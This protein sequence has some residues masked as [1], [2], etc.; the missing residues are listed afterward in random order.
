MSDFKPLCDYGKKVKIALMEQNKKQEWLIAE[1][2]SR[3]PDI[4]V[5][6]SNIHKI[7]TG[8]IASGK[9]VNAINEILAI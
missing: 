2:K 5:D 4:Y 3:F 8:E 6:G 9:V 7:L 1:I